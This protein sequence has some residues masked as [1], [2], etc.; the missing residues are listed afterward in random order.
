[1][2]NYLVSKMRKELF[3]SV[4]KTQIEPTIR[5]VERN[6]TVYTMDT[7]AIGSPNGAPSVAPRTRGAS[8][9]LEIPMHRRPGDPVFLHQRFDRC[10]PLPLGPQ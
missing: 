9:L 4:R 10:P 2:G 5:T 3:P 8:A 6:G 7:S 1:V